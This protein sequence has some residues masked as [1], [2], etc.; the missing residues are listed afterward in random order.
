MATV[1]HS[2]DYN[3]HAMEDNWNLP[4]NVISSC[5]LVQNTNINSLY[6]LLNCYHTGLLIC[7]LLNKNNKVYLLQFLTSG[8]KYEL[9]ANLGTCKMRRIIIIQVWAIESI[10]WDKKFVLKHSLKRYTALLNPS[11]TFNVY[12]INL[13]A[14]NV[15]HMRINCYFPA[16]P[17]ALKR[18]KT[19]INICHRF[20][21][22]QSKTSLWQYRFRLFS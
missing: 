4:E 20:Q 6:L 12:I 11:F 13:R 1:N 5:F 22:E 14:I 3:C 17:R 2:H 18:H 9:L 21:R 15:Q 8:P 19:E 10:F 16:N 7:V